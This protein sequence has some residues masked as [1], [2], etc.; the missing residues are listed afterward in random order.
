MVPLEIKQL[1][2]TAT[3]W[4]TKKTQVLYWKHQI[5]YGSAFCNQALPISNGMENSKT[6]YKYKLNRNGPTA[7]CL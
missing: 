2:I 3:Y 7:T 6:I 1:C 5:T 4:K